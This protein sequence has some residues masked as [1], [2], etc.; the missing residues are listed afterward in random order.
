MDEYIE[1]SFLIANGEKTLPKELVLSPFIDRIAKTKLFLNDNQTPMSKS[2][3][4]KMAEEI[5]K[6]DN[7]VKHNEK[8]HEKTPRKSGQ[9]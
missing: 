3:L 7:R 4:T 2:T 5:W 1:G 6:K 9:N 8:H